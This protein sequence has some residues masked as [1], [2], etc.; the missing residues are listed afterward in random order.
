MGVNHSAKLYLN[1]SK[2]E[3]LSL[4]VGFASHTKKGRGRG[5][6]RKE[7]D[8]RGKFIFFPFVKS[9]AQMH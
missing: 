5:W 4:F 3:W 6:S 1:S 9:N 2:Y 8:K 7:E